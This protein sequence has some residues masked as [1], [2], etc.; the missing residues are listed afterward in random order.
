MIK[1]AIAYFPDEPRCL[2][3]ISRHMISFNISGYMKFDTWQ[4]AEDFRKKWKDHFF[5]VNKL[6]VIEIKDK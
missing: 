5:D 1:F 2:V 6:I 3:S 4:E